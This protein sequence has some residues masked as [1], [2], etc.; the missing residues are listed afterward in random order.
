MH[1]TERCLL[2]VSLHLQIQPS[3]FGS[4]VQS[5]ASEYIVQLD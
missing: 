3:G 2:P 5:Y 4:G 1:N